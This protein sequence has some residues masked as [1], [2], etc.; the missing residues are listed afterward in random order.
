M[1]ENAKILI[2][3]EAHLF[4]NNLPYK[5]SPFSLSPMKANSKCF[6]PPGTN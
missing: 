6:F 5:V 3:N 1:H 2:V 4:I